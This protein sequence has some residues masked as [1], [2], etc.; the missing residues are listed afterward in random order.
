MTEKL[1][2]ETLSIK[3]NQ[4]CV[5]DHLIDITEV[6]CHVKALII[7]LRSWFKQD[8]YLLMIIGTSNNE[9]PKHY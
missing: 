2:T 5:N 4:N 3:P 1:F 8:V 6:C 9:Y 7:G